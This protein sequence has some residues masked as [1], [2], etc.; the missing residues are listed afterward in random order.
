MPLKLAKEISN[1]SHVGLW[2]IT[3]S[4]EDLLRN[5]QDVV[6]DVN[7]SLSY[8]NEHKRREF[9]ASRLLV[10]TLIEQL[11]E[12]YLGTDKENGKPILLDSEWKISLSHS[13]KYA[14]AYLNKKNTVGID[15]QEFDEKI[16]RVA[17]R[18]FSDL[19]L[20]DCQDDLKKLTAYWSIKEVLYK[21][22]PLGELDFIKELTVSPFNLASNGSCCACIKSKN[23]T[24]NI[25][26]SFEQTNDCILAY[27]E[28]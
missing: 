24:E 7:L 8:T 11:G 13:G 27:P 26:V 17:H 15:I 5:L 22:H 12:N 20:S 14:A 16:Y 10:K 3:E 25:T 6:H 2:E 4:S 9:L 28:K 23:M 19:E 1:D 18:V 21:I